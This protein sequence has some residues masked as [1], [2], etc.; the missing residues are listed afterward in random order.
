MEIKVLKH[1]NRSQ[2]AFHEGNESTKYKILLIFNSKFSSALHP[3][4]KET[5][6]LKG[7]FLCISLHRNSMSNELCS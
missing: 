3:H 1:K 5:E 4:M 7:M 2:R 6:T